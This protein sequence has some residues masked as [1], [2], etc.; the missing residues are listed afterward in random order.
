MGLDGVE[1]VM[2]W[3]ESF[4][5]T[6]T[7]AEAA[8]LRTPRLATD[9]IYRKLAAGDT[10]G[11]GGCLTQRAF[12]RLRSAFGGAFAVPR[13]RV[14]PSTLLDSL[15][16]AGRRREHWQALQTRVGVTRFPKLFFGRPPFGCNTVGGLAARLAARQPGCFRQPSEPWTRAQVRSLVRRLIVEQLGIKTF[17]DDDDFVRDLRVG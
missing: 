14:R 3:E 4:G 11:P 15:L 10:P 13:A 8:N 2:A 12:Y 5:I 7:D 9:L 6:I 16:P 1:L 17:S